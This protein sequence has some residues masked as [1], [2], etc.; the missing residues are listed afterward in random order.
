MTDDLREEGYRRT[1]RRSGSNKVLFGVCGGIGDYL[2]VDPELIRLVFV[3]MVLMPPSIGLL[4]YIVLAI[5][6]PPE[7]AVSGAEARS[8]VDDR[9]GTRGGALF[10]G[11][12]LVVLGGLMLL[13]NLQLLWW[14]D[15]A[16]LWPVFLV[17]IGVSLLLRGR[18]A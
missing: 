15:M 7:G 11:V 1:L 16:R 14:L 18:G 4:A 5:L 13:S 8:T 9:A 10:F 2:G 17:A 12:A 6:M 3:V